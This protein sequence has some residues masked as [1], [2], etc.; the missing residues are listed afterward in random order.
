MHKHKTIKAV[1][2]CKMGSFEAKTIFKSFVGG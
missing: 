2:C 1:Y